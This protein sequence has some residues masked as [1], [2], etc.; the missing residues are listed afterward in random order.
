MILIIQF[1]TYYVWH[2]NYYEAVSFSTHGSESWSHLSAFEGR[3]TDSS[4]QQKGQELFKVIPRT[5]NLSPSQNDKPKE[6]EE[7]DILETILSLLQIV[8]WK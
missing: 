8:K 3:N 2:M 6:D 4:I 1:E 7:V 5:S